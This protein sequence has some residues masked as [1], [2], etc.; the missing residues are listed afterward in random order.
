[1]NWKKSLC[2][3]FVVVTLG[4]ALCL[5]PTAGAGAAATATCSQLMKA[6]I[7]PLLAHHITKLTVTPV[8]GITYLSSA[9]H[10]GQTCVFADTE[11]SDALAVVV[12]GGAAAARAYQADLHSLGPPLARVQVVSGGKGVRER[13]DSQGSV[14]SAEVTSIKGSTYCAVI[15]QTDEVPGVAKLERAAGDSSAIGDKAY[16]DI[17]ASIGTVCNRIYGSGST[18]AGPALAALKKIKP[19]HGNGGTLTVPPL[20]PTP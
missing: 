17:A 5:V 15:P 19:K 11:N 2:V 20:P 3:S 18:N 10:V 1:M 8:A 7:Q 13:A 16:S 9:K 14:G 4:L 12:I 6:Q